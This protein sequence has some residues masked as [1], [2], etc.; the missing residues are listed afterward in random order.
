MPARFETL[1]HKLLKLPEASRERLANALLESLPNPVAHE[2]SQDQLTEF[3]RRSAE[4]AA[5]TAEIVS[6]CEV[7][8][9]VENALRGA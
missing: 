5:G 7:M 4:V 2:F 8:S 3:S 6:Y 9:E 1:E